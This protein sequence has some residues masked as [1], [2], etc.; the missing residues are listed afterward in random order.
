MTSTAHRLVLVLVAA[1]SL[2]AVGCKSSAPPRTGFISDYSQLEKVD[3][4]KSRFVSQKL[5]EYESFIVDPI[6]WRAKPEADKEPVLKPEEKAEVV[7][8]FREAFI[9]VLQEND[10]TVTDKTGVGV[11]RVR[12]AVTD[13]HESTWWANVH[14][15]SKL[16]G[17]GTGGASMEGEVID[18]MTGEQLAA[19]VKSGKG[20]QFTLN[21]GNTAED[22]E[23][24]IDQWAKEAE[25][26]LRELREASDS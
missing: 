25:E 11:A 15:G 26:R 16:T 20:S 5:A 7:N 22:V 3:D 19:V 1:L 12:L 8:Y 2:A 13:I 4:Q 18:S 17:A 6:Q 24:L 9:K 10:Y 23:N 21:I 14:P